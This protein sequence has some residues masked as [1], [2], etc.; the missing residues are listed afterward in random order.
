MFMGGGEHLIVMIG[1]EDSVFSNILFHAREAEAGSL[2]YCR[3]G[4]PWDG[5]CDGEPWP[6]SGI[7]TALRDSELPPPTARSLM[8]SKSESARKR[9]RLV[10]F[11]FQTKG[12]PDEHIVKR[13]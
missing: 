5:S 9:A 13:D 2:L 7:Q 4:L 8:L 12:I 3:G 6:S 10:T 11:F 1:E